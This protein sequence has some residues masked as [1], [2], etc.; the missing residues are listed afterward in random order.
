MSGEWLH[1]DSLSLRLK[2]KRNPCFPKQPNTNGHIFYFAMPEIA[3]QKAVQWLLLL[4]V[5]M[6][7]KSVIVR[8]WKSTQIPSMTE[9][10]H[11][12]QNVLVTEKKFDILFVR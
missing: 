6:A 10:T 4:A 9:W 2:Q 5:I 11:T 12:I 1:S 7:S 8:N 3:V